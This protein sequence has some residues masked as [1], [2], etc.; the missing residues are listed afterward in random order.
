MKPFYFYIL[1]CSDGSYYIGH[2]DNIEK[3][4]AEHKAKKYAGYTATRLPVRLKYTYEC[5]SRESVIELEQKVKKWSRRKK[6]A[7]IAQNWDLLKLLAKR[8]SI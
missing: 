8:K 7:L 5:E 1:Q 3:R 4:I 2:T 6:E